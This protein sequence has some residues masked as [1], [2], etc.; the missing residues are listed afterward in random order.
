MTSGVQL[1]DGWIAQM[2]SN[3]HHP[4]F[5]FL[6]YPTIP[7][8][9]PTKRHSEKFA[10]FDDV[11]LLCRRDNAA[12]LGGEGPTINRALEIISALVAHELVE[13]V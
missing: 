9:I 4:I 5:E 12:D 7:G 11:Q 6:R 8:I 2:I 10:H 3:Y 13:T 1:I